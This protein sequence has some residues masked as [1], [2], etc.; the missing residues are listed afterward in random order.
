MFAFD[1]ADSVASSFEGL[2]I[3][4]II[5]GFAERGEMVSYAYNDPTFTIN[6]DSETTDA[7]TGPYQLE[8]RPATDP[9]MSQRPVA[10]N[11]IRSSCCRR[12]TRTSGLP[13]RPRSS[14]RP[15]AR[16]TDGET[17]TISDGVDTLTFEFDNDDVVRSGNVRVPFE[18]GDTAQ[19]VGR[20]IRDAV[21]SPAVQS[22]LDITAS[23]SAATIRGATFADG[24][25]PTDPLYQVVDLAGTAIVTGIRH[26]MHNG[27]GDANRFRDQGQVIIHSNFVTDSRDFGI[28]ADAGTRDVEPRLAVGF[29]EPHPGAARNLRELNNHPV[30]GL[31]PGAV[32][33]NN[34][35]HNE[36]L[37]GIHVS[38]NVAPFEIVPPSDTLTRLSGQFVGTA[39]PSPSTRIARP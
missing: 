34:V 35:I 10:G 5:I 16:L 14:R 26:V 13:S 31:A 9:G 29:L 19:Q 36:G 30:G 25:V 12:S 18:A 32:I 4:D 22:A 7:L 28:V 6:P 2:L 38:G 24:S 8:I 37:G 33:E 3:D 23:V 20:S 17:F 15:A 1:S 39:R 27:F 21:N 11:R